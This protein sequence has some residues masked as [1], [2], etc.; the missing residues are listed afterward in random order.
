[1]SAK[2]FNGPKIEIAVAAFAEVAAG[3]QHRI[4]VSL[5]IV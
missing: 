5:T 1:M 3:R 2:G 4:A